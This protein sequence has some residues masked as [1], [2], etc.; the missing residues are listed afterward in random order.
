EMVGRG[1]VM[2]VVR[3][4]TSVFAGCTIATAVEA[5]GRISVRGS[6]RT[7]RFFDLFYAVDFLKSGMH[8]RDGMLWIRTP[9]RRHFVNPDKVPLIQVAPTLLQLMGLPRPAT[10]PGLPIEQP[11]ERRV[12]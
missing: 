1:S 3:K 6:D 8:H 9:E 10:M 12:A 7:L 5:E 2:Y 4:G 11:R